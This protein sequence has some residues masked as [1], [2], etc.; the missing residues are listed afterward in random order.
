VKVNALTLL[1]LVRPEPLDR[2]AGDLAFP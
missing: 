1:E 2:V